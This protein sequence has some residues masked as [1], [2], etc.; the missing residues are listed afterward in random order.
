[1]KQ[2][3]NVA[4][5]PDTIVKDVDNTLSEGCKQNRKKNRD[6]RQWFKFVEDI[7]EKHI[8]QSKKDLDD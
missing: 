3:L 4:Y 6:K 5:D 1:M 7:M 2:F 8:V